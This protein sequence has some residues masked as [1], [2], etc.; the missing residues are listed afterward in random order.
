VLIAVLSASL[1]I[2]LWL[3]ADTVRRESVFVN[4]L[5]AF[6]ALCRHLCVCVCLI[7]GSAF[8]IGVRRVCVLVSAV[9][10]S[11]H[12]CNFPLSY[13]AT[14]RC[15][16]G[17][18]VARPWPACSSAGGVVLCCCTVP[19]WLFGR[20]GVSCAVRLC[21][22]LSHHLRAVFCGWKRTLSID[23]CLRSRLFR[24]HPVC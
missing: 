5:V 21:L 24:S 17:R 23:S 6:P 2:N 11:V 10:V 8:A 22:C 9:G 4:L 1:G 3:F 12:A 7:S 18:P 20:F 14:H 15:R 13:V 16:V 19:T